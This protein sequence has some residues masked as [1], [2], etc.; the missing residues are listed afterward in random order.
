MLAKLVALPAVIVALSGC[1]QS[2]SEHTPDLTKLPLV[3]GARVLVQV[4]QCDPGANAFCAWELVVAGPGYRS[5]AALVK[6]EHFHLKS[7]GWTSANADTGQQQ[8]ADSPG[9]RL[10]LTYATPDGDLRGIDLGWV[11]RSRTI[12]L[13]LSRAIFEHR[14]AISMLY[15]AGAS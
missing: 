13:A 12:T 6:A 15:E 14:S 10:R 3:R 7:L 2:R 9:H 4:R 8:A 1:G 11:K 5:S